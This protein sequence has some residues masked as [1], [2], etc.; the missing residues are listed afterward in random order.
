MLD[1]ANLEVS[2]DTPGGV[3]E[4]VRG[5]SFTVKPGRTFAIVGESGSGKSV[6]AMTLLGLTPDARVRGS[7]RFN[8]RDLL[9]M[10]ERELRAIRG[11]EIS[12]IFQD[13]QSSLNPCFTIGWQVAEVLRI[14]ERAPRAEAKRRA[15]DLLRQV[16]IPDP[17]R[18]ADDYPHQFSGGMLQRVMIAMA[19]ALT[20]RLIIADEPTTALDVTV[21]AQILDLLQS[22]QREQG[23][24]LILITHDLGV[25]ARI[26][27]DVLVMYAG[28][29]METAPTR[30][31]FSAPHHPY[32]IGLI[33]SLPRADTVGSLLTPIRGQPPSMISPPG[34]C[35]FHTRC[36]FARAR[37]MEDQP[38]HEVRGDPQ[39]HS[40]CWLPPA[41]RDAPELQPAG[42]GT[43]ERR[44]VNGS[45][46]ATAPDFRQ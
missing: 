15:V 10:P 37:C 33:N 36:D 8:G 13:P 9:T 35:P 25:V 40:A 45:G 1:V 31:L 2:F 18:R 7:A 29:A 23:T 46:S 24:A 3:V 14:H 32:T 22:L 44:P 28:R 5:I 34:G 30:T 43:S 11:A 20:P 16:G 17:E 19:I 39:H 42:R 21:Q 27:D 41:E 26:A 12:M 4:A 6:A 38:L